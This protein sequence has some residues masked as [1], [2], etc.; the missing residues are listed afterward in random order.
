[1]L[2]LFVIVVCWCFMD[3]LLM[4]LFCVCLCFGW[5]FFVAVLL[6]LLWGFFAVLGVGV[7]RESVSRSSSLTPNPF[8]QLFKNKPK[9]VTVK[10]N[11]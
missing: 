11:S 5:G 6:L 3:V 9:Y 1:M 8:K 4:L 2:L 7:M 10:N